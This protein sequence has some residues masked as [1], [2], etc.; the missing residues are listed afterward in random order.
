L[1]VSAAS[2]V[3]AVNSWLPSISTSVGPL[4]AI[5]AIAAPSVLLRSWVSAHSLPSSGAVATTSNGSPRLLASAG[6]CGPAAT[7]GTVFT[8][9]LAA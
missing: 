4:P 7:V 9:K 8:S 6:P 3:R 2:A 1:A 5:T